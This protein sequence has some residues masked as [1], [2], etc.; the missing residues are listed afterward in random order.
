[1]A[2]ITAEELNSLHRAFWAGATARRDT[3]LPE[4]GVIPQIAKLLQSEI[5]RGVPHANRLSF[6]GA[7]EEFD[8]LRRRSR[9]SDGLKGGRPSRGDRLQRWIEELLIAR[10]SLRLKDLYAAIQDAQGGNVISDVEDEKITYYGND[11]RPRTI[12][13]SSLR[14]RFYRAKKKV[15]GA[16]KKSGA[17]KKVGV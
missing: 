9:R 2:Q 13:F 4:K 5:T 10:P 15:F 12:L 7:C 1:M 11:G 8:D 17:E 6:E 14:A 3:L 16:K